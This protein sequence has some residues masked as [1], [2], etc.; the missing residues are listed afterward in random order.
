ME[1]SERSATHSTIRDQ[2][3][4]GKKWTRVQKVFDTAHPGYDLMND[5]MSLGLHRTLK[6]MTLEQ[7]GVR[8]GHRVLDLAGG[9]GDLARLFARAVTEQGSLVLADANQQML[10][11]GRDRLLNRAVLNVDYC[12]ATAE[13]LPFAAN[14]FDCIVCGFGFRNFSDQ[15]RAIKESNRVLKPGGPFL[16]LEF[17]KP[18]NAK[19]AQAFRLYRSTWPMLGKF[20]AGDAE[21]YDYLVESI[22]HHPT[23]EAVELMLRD[24]DFD[25][26][27]WHRLLGGAVT[28]HRAVK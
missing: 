14:S 8:P 20:V 19:F 26:V 6:R 13:Q 9:T 3:T 23:P 18:K 22:E 10:E 28:L 12:L 2:S 5:L 15:E 27:R 11:R 7:S 16:I 4:G 1:N 17:S 25:Q 21:P 24:G